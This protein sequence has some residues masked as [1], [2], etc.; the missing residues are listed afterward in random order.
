MIRISLVSAAGLATGVLLLGVAIALPWA[1]IGGRAVGPEWV[2]H[3]AYLPTVLLAMAASISAAVAR[4]RPW[5]V[6]VS[7]LIGLLAGYTSLALARA[8]PT[9]AA[10]QESADGSRGPAFLAILAAEAVLIVTAWSTLLPR[11]S[12]DIYRR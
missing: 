8:I 1:F 7:S 11:R 9:M 10:V 12:H 4:F 5:T 2:G 3:A 6:A